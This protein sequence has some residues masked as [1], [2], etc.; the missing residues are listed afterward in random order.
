VAQSGD[1][2]RDSGAEWRASG[3]P[4]IFNGIPY[5]LAGPRVFF[6]SDV[7]VRVGTFEG[8]PLYADT[9]LEANSIIYVSVGGKL[10]QPYERRRSGELAGTEGSRTPSFPVDLSGGSVETEPLDQDIEPAA[11]TSLLPSP[12]ASSGQ[13]R[14]P[15][16]TDLPHDNRC[17]ETVRVE[18]VKTDA[19]V[20]V[21]GGI[22][23]NFDH[24]TW[25]LSSARLTPV[26]LVIVGQVNGF[27]VYR[28]RARPNEVFVPSTHRGPLVRYVLTTSAPASRRTSPI[29]CGDRS[30]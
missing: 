1:A 15:A 12:S 8:V 26:S 9:T 20:P 13:T 28:D 14:E 2:V 27:P 17:V 30:P 22:W 25:V 29:P 3:A 4:L 11:P 10:M 7:M 23:I 21:T 5:Y 16:L 18:S 6:N 19:R 24:K